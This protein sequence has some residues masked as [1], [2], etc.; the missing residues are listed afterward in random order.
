MSN[1]PAIGSATGP[2]TGNGPRASA[3]PGAWRAAD[4]ADLRDITFAFERRHL[5]AL[6]HALVTAR[7]TGRAT[8]AI[9]REDFPLDDI[10][11]DLDSIRHRVQK[12]CGIVLLRGLPVA[13]YSRE[14]LCRMFWGL[15]THFGHAVSQSLLGDRL[16]HVTNVSGDNPAERGYRSRR[17]LNMHTDS[18]DLLMMMC[19]RNAKSGG[20]SRFVSAMTV[21]NEMLNGCPELLAPLMRGF[22]YHWRGEQAEGEDPITRFRVPVFSHCKGAFSCVYLRAFIDMAAQE[23][24]EPLSDEERTALDTFEALC[25]R[26]DLQLA[27]D[28]KPGDAYLVNNYTTLHSRTA[29]VDHARPE[30]RR[31]LLRL[32]LKA[33]DGRP[34]VDAVRRFYRDDGITGRENAGTMYLHAHADP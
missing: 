2:A 18:D 24:G 9:R 16:G 17:E 29:F 10:Q 25:E 33:V 6:D 19:L 23:L 8:E 15:G 1:P 14:D 3:H 28:L 7:A 30:E 4:F 26:A 5:Q 13:R 32:W 27:I 20:Q 22:R 12:Q 31:Y 11:D 21:Y 34:V